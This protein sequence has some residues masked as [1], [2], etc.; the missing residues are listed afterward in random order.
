ML[1][2]KHFLCEGKRGKTRSAAA[3]EKSRTAKNPP[4]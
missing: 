1:A 2:A 3:P 4:T